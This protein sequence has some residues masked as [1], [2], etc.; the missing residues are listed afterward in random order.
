MK[1]LGIVGVSLFLMIILAWNSC[2]RIPPGYAGFRLNYSGNYKGTDSIPLQTGW[3][4]FAPGF[5]TVIK[6]PTFMQHKAWT[7][8]PDEDSRTNEEISIG[9]K[10]GASFTLDIGLNY[11][12][13]ADRCSH[14]YF[15]FKTDDLETIT[16]GYL[17]NSTRKILNDLAGSYTVDSLL[18]YRP[19]YEKTA[20]N[21]LKAYLAPD[22]FIVNQLS[23]I[24][25]PRPT[26]SAIA[27]A[28]SNKIK[29]KQDAETSITLLQQ[30]IADA[31]RK[32]ATARGDSQAIVISASAQAKANEVL[33]QTLTPLLIQKQ[34]LEKWDGHLP[35]YMTGTGSG[36]LL[37]VPKQ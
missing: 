2:T 28:I 14:I 9:C 24:T 29:A 36:I 17:R 7:A 11:T 10:G 32:I 5:S 23:I 20:E 22:G 34:Y 31:N 18:T 16:N 37:Q 35:T 13:D 27:G 30:S 8:S 25:T 33:L 6:F 1:I 4:W 12:V 15:K 21:E 19:E 26:D 3:V